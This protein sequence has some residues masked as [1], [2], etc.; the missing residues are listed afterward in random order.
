MT[1]APTTQTA[2]AVP[3][4]AGTAVFGG[5]RSGSLS[6][7]RA[8]DFKR[9]PL[10]FRFRVIDR[11]PEAPSSAAV[12]GTVVH[13]A[14]EQVFDVPAPQRTLAH[15]QSLLAPALAE[16][17][18]ERPEV[19]RL[20]DGTSDDAEWLAEA[21]RLVARW[22]ELED[23]TAL[24]PAGREVPL[25]HR[26]A[27]DLV[28]RGI[29]DRVDVAPDGRIRIVDYK[30]GRA[31]G[32]AFEQRAMFQMKFYALL[33]WR[34][35]GRV[36]TRVQLVYVGGQGQSL[37]LDVDAAQLE[38]FERTLLSLWQAIRSA[39]ESG[40][41]RPR[42]SR[43]C[44][45]CDHR[46]LCPAWGGQA[47]PLPQG[48]VDRVLRSAHVQGTAEESTDQGTRRLHQDAGPCPPVDGPGGFPMDPDAG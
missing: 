8:A 38:A 24:E 45:W 9:C 1:S 11:L 20:F 34:T 4:D 5:S 41:W 22:F 16:V 27:D 29:I 21:E 26:V 19:A 46:A 15:A 40:D 23:P 43:M 13:R 31:P 47:P 28:L 7:S 18:A 30:T 10:L 3:P 25:E 35:G 36:P 37:P 6:P 42:P 12:R 14:L 17:C 2:T 44:Q 32:E 48:A 33:L 39:A